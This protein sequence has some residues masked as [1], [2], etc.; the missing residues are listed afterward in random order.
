MNK[1]IAH[2]HH[3]QF[4]TGTLDDPFKDERVIVKNRDTEE[5]VSK[6]LSYDCILKFM[7]IDSE[8]DKPLMKSDIIKARN[9]M[10]NIW[11]KVNKI[12]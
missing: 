1:D 10:K 2:I 8:S 5:D 7:K 12:G 9:V 3:D 11:I 4:L 6:Y